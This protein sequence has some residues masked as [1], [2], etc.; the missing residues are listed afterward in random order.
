MK[1]LTLEQQLSILVLAKSDY[2][3]EIADPNTHLLGGM[4]FYVF[5]AA[6]EL[7]GKLKL[8]QVLNSC[9]ILE[10]FPYLNSLKPKEAYDNGFWWDTEQTVKRKLCFDKSIT[11]L[12][13]QIK[14]Q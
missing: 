13:R 4:C 10:L 8:T 11:H 3:N 9:T 2:I 1:E 6:Y 14:K 5:E 12:C 7:S